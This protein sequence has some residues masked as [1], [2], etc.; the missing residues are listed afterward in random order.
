MI[1]RWLFALLKKNSRRRTSQVAGSGLVE[2]ERVFC[3]SDVK[4]QRAAGTGVMAVL[5]DRVM[6]L[7]R[8]EILDVR[9]SSL[10]EANL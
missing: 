6:A 8:H 1:D 4:R 5:M 3:P 10:D 7:M 9:A 2:R